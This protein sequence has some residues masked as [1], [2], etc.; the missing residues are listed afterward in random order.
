[1]FGK[2]RRSAPEIRTLIGSGTRIT[3]DLAFT[4]GLHVDGV[5]VGNVSLEGTADGNLSISKDGVVEGSV[6]VPEVILNGTVKGDVIA[7]ERVQL[8]PTARVVGN[9]VYNL[10]EMAIGA[11][12]NGQLIHKAPG[13][14][15]V[16]G[17]TQARDQKSGESPPARSLETT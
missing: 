7:C 9:V 11:E 10:I 1:M 4:E 13:R 8:G 17:A 6:E 12:V 2:T 14:P 16:I 5:I 3:G 15:D